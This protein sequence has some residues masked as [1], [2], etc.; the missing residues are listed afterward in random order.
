MTCHTVQASIA[1]F[2]SL[3]VGRILKSSQIVSFLL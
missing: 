1:A 3:D 2:R